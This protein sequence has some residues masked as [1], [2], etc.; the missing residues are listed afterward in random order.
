MGFTALFHWALHPP[1]PFSLVHVL[2]DIC[3]CLL[4]IF[5]R[6]IQM[7]PL[8]LLQHGGARAVIRE[9]SDNPWP[10]QDAPFQSTLSH[11]RLE[12]ENRRKVTYIK[13]CCGSFP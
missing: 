3:L 10:V 13:S 11:L 12:L 5:P 2:G 9:L 8:H 4:E 1:R 7:Q 6:D